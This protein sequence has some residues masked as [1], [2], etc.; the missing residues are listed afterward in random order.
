MKQFPLLVSFLLARDAVYQVV[1][2]VAHA[3]HTPWVHVLL[4]YE[5]GT[6]LLALVKNFDPK[7]LD[8]TDPEAAS[9]ILLSLRSWRNGKNWAQFDSVFV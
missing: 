4:L 8:P 1:W 7:L 6:P 3:L 9:T 5:I 2:G